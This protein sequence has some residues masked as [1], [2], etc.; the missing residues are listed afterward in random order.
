MGKCRIKRGKAI[1]VA[2]IMVCI[3][4]LCLVSCEY[5][6]FDDLCMEEGVSIIT[7]KSA[8]ATDVEE[9][10]VK[11]INNTEKTLTFSESFY[12]VKKVNDKWKK[13]PIP[14]GTSFN[15]IAYDIQPYSTANHT[16]KVDYVYSDLKPGIYRIVTSVVS[17]DAYVYAEFTLTDDSEMLEA[18]R[19]HFYRTN[20]GPTIANLPADS[21]PPSP[22]KEEYDSEVVVIETAQQVQEMFGQTYSQ[23]WSNEE[24]SWVRDEE[25]TNLINRYD[26]EFFESSQLVTFVV[27]AS[28]GANY[29]VFTKAV[30]EDGVLTIEISQKAHGGDGHGHEAIVSWFALIEIEKVPA[31][32]QIDYVIKGRGW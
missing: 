21:Y 23:T 3:L 13:L 25:F 17:D 18:S 15:D 2:I 10:Q 31:D 29:F 28:G 19:G 16:Y 6:D 11:W 24:Q 4:S 7:E 9:I 20:L 30:C 32:T 26:E 5:M 12:L 27:S 14:Y 22:S 8:Y 1:I